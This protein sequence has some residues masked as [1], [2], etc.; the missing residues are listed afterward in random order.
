M[1]SFQVYLKEDKKEVQDVIKSIGGGKLSESVFE[2][3]AYI[4]AKT[5]GSKTLPTIRDVE[6]AMSESEFDDKGKKWITDFLSKT[7]DNTFLLQAIELIGGD[8]KNIPNVNWGS[9]QVLHKSIDKYYK[10]TPKKYA[11]GAKD[12]TADMVLITKGT[13]DSLLKALP[14]ADMSWDNNGKVKIDGTDIEF[15]QVSLKKGQETARI[16]KLSSLINQIYGQQAMRPSQLTQDVSEDIQQLEEGL[17]AIFG[18]TVELIKLG[19][20][21]LMS[22]AKKVLTKLRNTLL[23]S[24]IRITKTITRDKAHKSASNLVKLLGGGNLTEN[25]IAE[26]VLP[27]V[28]I[29]APLLKEMKILKGEIIAKDLANKEYDTLLRNVKAINSAKEGSVVIGNKGTSPFL[30]MNNFKAAA[31]EVLSKTIGDTITRENINPA[32]KLVVNYASYRTFNTILEGI[33]S[34]ISSYN[35]ISDSLVGLNAKLRAEAMFGK[36]QLPLWIVYGMGGGAH[37]KHTKDE[38]ESSTKEDIL[39]LGESMDVPY[40][41]ISIAKSSKNPSYNAIYAYLLVG[42]VNQNDQLQPEY[43]MLQFINRSGS[44]WS[45]KIDASS[46]IVGVPNV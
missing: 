45:Y 6:S 44:D 17:R 43:L 1:K 34:N 46:S 25:Y 16:G 8:M 33:L 39:K 2:A 29:N 31:D 3:W 10:N 42:A 4:I 13:V 41:Y 18:K 5:S 40:M 22:F 21:K 36:T 35:K 14:N 32:L 23:K 38:F 27:P 20:S 15:V 19:A 7:E 11:E 37:Y 9:V 12:N 28:T 30:E 24:A 26:K